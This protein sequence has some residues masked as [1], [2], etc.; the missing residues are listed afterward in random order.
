MREFQ[1]WIK[2]LLKF[3]LGIFSK[4]LIAL[5]VCFLDLKFH[6]ISVRG[7]PFFPG[8]IN[9]LDFHIFAALF[10]NLFFCRLC[11][12]VFRNILYAFRFKIFPVP[13]NFL[14]SVLSLAIWKILSLQ[15]SGLLSSLRSLLQL[16]PNFLESSA[17]FLNQT[18]VDDYAPAN[19]REYQNSGSTRSTKHSLQP[20]IHG[21]AVG[22]S[23]AGTKQAVNSGE[24]ED[25]GEEHTQKNAFLIFRQNKATPKKKNGM[26]NAPSPNNLLTRRLAHHRPIFPPPLSTVERELKISVPI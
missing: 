25:K 22:S 20:L 26:M 10:Q 17:D 6:T 21:K 18:L 24:R 7:F 13:F 14:C 4:K 11:R 1:A 8:G 5:N 9:K 16:L 2:C 3:F 19:Y 23:G 12:I 15:V